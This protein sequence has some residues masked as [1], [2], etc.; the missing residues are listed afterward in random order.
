MNFKEEIIELEKNTSDKDFEMINGKIPVL[1]SAPHAIEQS[2]NRDS[3]KPGETFTKAIALYL[4]K[5]LN[6]YS[7]VK[8]NDTGLDANRDNR[9]DYKTE[10][11]RI[12]RNNEIKLVIDLHGARKSR[13]F[14][15]EFGTLNNLTADFSTV[16]ELEEAFNENG[17]LNVSYNDPFKGG[18]ITQYLYGIK[19]VDVVQI[20]INGKY[21][22]INDIESLKKIVES[23]E[24]FIK[25]YINVTR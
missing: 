24:S 3:I 22:D 5:H 18:A 11:L 19:D 15:V 10:L 2:L 25:Q 13:E 8:Y 9:D 1:I 4:N 16:R 14:D 20:E 23:L 17:I 12:V 6:T 7:I 21:R